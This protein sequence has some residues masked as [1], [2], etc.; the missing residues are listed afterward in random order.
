MNLLLDD[1]IPLVPL[2]RHLANGGYQLTTTGKM[3]E[4]TLMGSDC[5]TCG[6]WYHTLDDNGECLPCHNL[7]IE[8]GN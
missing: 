7:R 3:L 1:S 5:A 6:E 8:N 2:A 4:L